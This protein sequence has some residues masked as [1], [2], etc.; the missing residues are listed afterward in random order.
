[1]NIHTYIHMLVSNL[2]MYVGL[3]LHRELPTTIV[4][5]LQRQQGKNFKSNKQP[6]AF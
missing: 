2:Y 4:S 5:Y 1:M 3:E 6:S